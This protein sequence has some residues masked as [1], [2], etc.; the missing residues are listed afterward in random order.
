MM[1]MMMMKYRSVSLC[2]L[3][4]F[5]RCWQNKYKLSAE[6]QIWKNCISRHRREWAC[7]IRCSYLQ[8]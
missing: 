8:L 6:Y 7:K 2:R 1:M 5:E 3:Q 4:H